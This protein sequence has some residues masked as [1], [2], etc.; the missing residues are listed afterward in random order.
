MRTEGDTWDI[1]SSVGMPAL[2][3]AAP[4]ASGSGVA[5][6]DDLPPSDIYRHLGDSDWS[7]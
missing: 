1:V 3:V 2:G 7:I 6:Q 5:G 4:R